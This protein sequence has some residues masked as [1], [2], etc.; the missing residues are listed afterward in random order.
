MARIRSLKPEF[1]TDEK[2]VSLSSFARLL[3]IGM[4]NFVDDEG[5][6]EFSPA[7]LKMQI[8]P[9]DTVDVAELLAEI[10]RECLIEVYV[11]DGKQYFQVKGFAKHQKVDKRG[12]SKFPP[13]PTPPEFPRIPPTDQGMEGKGEGSTVAIATGV[14]EA[15]KQPDPEPAEKPIEVPKSDEDRF[16]DVATALEA[17]G[18]ARSMCGRLAQALN[19]E[20]SQ[21]LAILRSVEQARTPPA[22]LGKVLTE[23]QPKAAA[24]TKPSSRPDWVTEA[25]AQGYPVKQEGK[26]WRMAGAL[27]DDAGEQVGC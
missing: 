15:E 20:F 26:R 27:Y 18:V 19:G 12:P 7:R 17:R 25:E 6:A 16:W 11:V 4:W 21:G 13:P 14:V 24:K 3:F 5:R 10:R 23:R 2:V 22:Y 9:A 1:W 8:L